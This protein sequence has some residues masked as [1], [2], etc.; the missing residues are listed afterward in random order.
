M[1][2]NLPPGCMRIGISWCEYFKLQAWDFWELQISEWALFFRKM[3]ILCLK[4]IPNFRVSVTWSLCAM[5]QQHRSQCFAISHSKCQSSAVSG[6]IPN[7]C[8]IYTHSGITPHSIVNW[9]KS[10]AIGRPYCPQEWISEFHAAGARSSDAH[11]ELSQKQKIIF[12]K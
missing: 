11:G 7:W 6:H 2:L 9:I 8:L 1:H 10:R 12:P 3:S 4:K 5:H